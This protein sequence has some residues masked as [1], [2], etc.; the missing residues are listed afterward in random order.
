VNGKRNTEILRDNKEH[1]TTNHWMSSPATLNSPRVS[2]STPLSKAIH[3]LPPQYTDHPT[4]GREERVPKGIERPRKDTS[5]YS[6]AQL[7]LRYARTV[8]CIHLLSSSKLPLEPTRLDS[9]STQYDSNTT[10]ALPDLLL[11]ITSPHYTASPT[12]S[13]EVTSKPTHHT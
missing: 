13:P 10:P 12:N 5:L 11:H 9:A 1:K 4:L 8:L 6:R 3:V 7:H 2:H